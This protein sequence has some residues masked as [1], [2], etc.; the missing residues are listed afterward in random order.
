M[1]TAEML[2][3]ILQLHAASCVLPFC[4]AE[5]FN[6]GVMNPESAAAYSASKVRT[7]IF[8]GETVV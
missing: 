4:K 6:L 7:S 5:P 8:R 3:L 1:P 2:G